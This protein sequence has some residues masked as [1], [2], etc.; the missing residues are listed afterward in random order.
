MRM[1]GMEIL[2]RSA[3]DIAKLDGHFEQL[4]NNE[5]I[6]W[7]T[8]DAGG[9]APV[10]VYVNKAFRNTINNKDA[11]N[12]RDHHRNTFSFKL[13]LELGDRVE[14]IHSLTGRPLS[15]G[16]RRVVDTRYLPR[17]G[18][19]APVKQEARYL[20]EWIAYHRVMG[21]DKFI[22]GDNGGTDGTSELLQCLKNANI[23]EVSDWRK[24]T[25]FQLEFYRNVIPMMTSHV[26]L[27]AIH[28][29]DEFIRPLNGRPNIKVALS[30]IFHSA[31]VTA[32]ATNYAIYGSS[33]LDNYDNRPVL[34]RFK[35]RAPDNFTMHKFTKSIIRPE[36]FIGMPNAHE[37][38][39]EEGDY[40]NDIGDIR[41]PMS[42]SWNSLRMDHYVIKSREEF[43]EKALRGRV[44]GVVPHKPRD[45]RFFQVRDQN[46]VND[47]APSSV[48]SR[49]RAEIQ[50]IIAKARI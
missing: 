40:V 19:V 12:T 1:A 35:K 50:N 5:V 3:Q 21:V 24:A 34:E 11:D 14:L 42:I 25:H 18:L 39:I 30:E 9:F 13:D 2:S 10:L 8:D 33:G 23:V 7:S 38:N 6:G 31:K 28:D 16:V 20:I 43:K 44:F 46:Q 22:L 17:V 15:G 26:E 47:P 37:V 32:A 27:C 4:N 49:V 45:E 48:I 36:R 41:V 29:V